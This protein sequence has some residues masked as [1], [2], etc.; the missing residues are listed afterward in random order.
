M[1][2]EYKISKD[3]VKRF[4]E[5]HEIPVVG[6]ESPITIYTTQL[7]ADIA[8]KTDDTVL[9]TVWKVGVDVDKDELVKALKFDRYQ[10]EKGFRIGFEAAFAKLP[11]WA[12]KILHR[13]M[14]K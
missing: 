9:E 14:K 8:K 4:A 12:R 13:R 1:K 3:E 7:A 11:W 5:I 6:Y 10:Y 2:P